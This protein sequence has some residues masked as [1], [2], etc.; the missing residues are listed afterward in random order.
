MLGNL[1]PIVAQG[2]AELWAVL[3]K[4]TPFRLAECERHCLIMLAL[5]AEDEVSAHFLLKKVKLARVFSAASLPVT[6][7]RMNSRVDYRQDG[8]P[9]RRVL[10]RHP[11]ALTTHDGGAS[12]AGR[13]GAGL[14][15]LE[16][17]QSALWPDP[18]GR[19]SPLEILAV[20]S[21]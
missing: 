12:V 18:A 4:A 10:L 6:V 3:H 9:A 17:G 5:A 14:I 16:V 7:A 8:G 13:L 11:P 20:E 1:P 2:Q 19:L 15:G 21:E